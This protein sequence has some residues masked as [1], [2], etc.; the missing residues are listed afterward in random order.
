[1]HKLPTNPTAGKS[2]PRRHFMWTVLFA[3]IS[4]ISGKQTFA[5]EEMEICLIG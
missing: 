4:A 1:M 5:V 2:A 3:A